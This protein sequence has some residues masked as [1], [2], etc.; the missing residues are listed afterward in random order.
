MPFFNFFEKSAAEQPL[1]KLS[2]EALLEKL[3][4]ARHEY[5]DAV[6]AWN[7]IRNPSAR[8]K[9][10]Y[11]GITNSKLHEKFIKKQ[12]EETAKARQK[13]RKIEEEIKRRG[14]SP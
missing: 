9:A 13:L 10:E 1:D 12:D 14:L 2:E 7:I 8:I 4:V 3:R 11:P 5:D 6:Q